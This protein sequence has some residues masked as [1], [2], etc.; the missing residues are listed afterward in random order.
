MQ[1]PKGVYFLAVGYIL[2]GGLFLAR[3]LTG[4]KLS[5]GESWPYL[6]LLC[7][8]ATALLR[9]R[10]WGR[11]LALIVCSVFWMWILIILVQVLVGAMLL[12]LRFLWLALPV[13]FFAWAPW[14]ML[15]PH[16]KRAFEAS[17][18]G[19]SSNHQPKP[20]SESPPPP[21]AP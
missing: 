9:L 7:V 1:R 13:A 20:P 5:P 4:G 16:V 2:L 6:L 11:I 10:N 3:S 21:A 8:I 15:R 19:P 18:R 14:Y 12:Q 17:K